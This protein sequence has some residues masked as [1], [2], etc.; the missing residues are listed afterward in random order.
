M[1][2][3]L[4]CRPNGIVTNE[5]NLDIAWCGVLATLNREMLDVQHVYFVYNSIDLFLKNG[6]VT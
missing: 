4:T 2:P 6:R 3:K 1:V 5:L